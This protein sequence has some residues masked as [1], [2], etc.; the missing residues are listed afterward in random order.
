M[1]SELEVEHK[2]GAPIPTAIKMVSF[3]SVNGGNSVYLA[4]IMLLSPGN[5]I[6]SEI[7]YAYAR[8]ELR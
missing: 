3:Q 6:V 7:L 2:N 1:G 5:D 4:R 8:G